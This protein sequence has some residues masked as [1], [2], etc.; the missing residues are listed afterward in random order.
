VSA[1]LWLAIVFITPKCGIILYLIFGIN[2]ITPDSKKIVRYRRR[3]QKRVIKNFNLESCRSNLVN[4]L[5][6]DNRIFNHIL[7]KILPKSPIITGNSITLLNDGTETIPQMLNAIANAKS[8]IH[9]CSYIFAD[10]QVGNK[11]T[12]LLVAKSREGIKVRVIADSLGS[13]PS[14]NL[15]HLKNLKLDNL[16]VRPH[17]LFSFFAPYRIQLRNHKKLLIVDGYVAFIGGINISKLSDKASSNKIIH[18]LHCMIHGPTV[19][20]LQFHFINDWCA[21]KKIPIEKIINED[22]YFPTPT[23]FGNCSIRISSSGPSE[24]YE[25]THQIYLTAAQTVSAQLW[26]IT[27]YFVPD[28]PLISSLILAAARGVDVR[29]IVPRIS[30]HLIVK[31][32][33]RSYYQT[34][35]ENGIRI[36][37][38]L[39]NFSH[40]KAM[41]VDNDWTFMGSSNCDCRSFRLNYELDF[42]CDQGPFIHDLYRQFLLEFSQ[43]HELRYDEHL[44]RSLKIK[45]LEN[46]CS[47][48]S[49]IL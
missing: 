15:Q 41:I 36:Y 19:N 14:K 44:N 9:L 31:F 3:F 11:I 48:F 17:A 32:A 28:M 12:K 1:V 18:D 10:D 27:P 24:N 16:E 4:F 5:R 23:I 38:H 49:P 43:A 42:I 8:H 2:R 35:L 45:L 21:A 6:D 34:L 37:E 33:S 13:F 20:D 25:A 26:I 22:N 39:G 46:F 30:D 47:L 7:N 40:S 29:I